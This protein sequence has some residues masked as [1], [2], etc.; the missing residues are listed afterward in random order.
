MYLSGQVAKAQWECLN[1]NK[2][3]MKTRYLNSLGSCRAVRRG[4]SYCAALLLV[5]FSGGTLVLSLDA[6]NESVSGPSTNLS[7]VAAKAP[8]AK[9][10]GASKAA[11]N[12][13]V[14]TIEQ[15]HLSGKDQKIQVRVDGTGPL[16]YNAFRLNEPDRLVID[17]WRRR[18]R[19]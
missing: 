15:V 14:A 18:P 7:Q 4:V 12:S 9:S 11:T 16:T 10:L 5:V 13:P 8:E 17:F 2:A 6:Q 3:Q 1:S 19:A